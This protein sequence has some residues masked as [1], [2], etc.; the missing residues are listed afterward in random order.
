MSEMRQNPRNNLEHES[1]HVTSRLKQM[2]S[3][4]LRTTPSEI[5]KENQLPFFVDDMDAR[6]GRYFPE[7][8]AGFS[9]LADTLKTRYYSTDDEKFIDDL[10]SGISRLLLSKLKPSEI[11]QRFIDVIKS[12]RGWEFVNSI[13][14]YEIEG[15]EL[16]LHIPPT[17]SRNILEQAALLKSG[18]E[19]F[20]RL[21]GTDER[22]KDVHT[23]TA[24][25]WIVYEHQKTLSRL[26]W[27]ILD[28]DEKTKEASALITRDAFLEMFGGTEK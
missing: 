18:L 24:R 20:A 28:V 26:G 8:S 23:I 17:F 25:S 22:M 14:G 12:E 10:C 6:M 4:R 21:L 9:E 19:Q 5:E 3:Q 13:L 16:I 1:E 11:D 27:S 7:C 2:V 15:N